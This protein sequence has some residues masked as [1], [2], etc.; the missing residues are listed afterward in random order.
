MPAK[1]P[2]SS[3][4]SSSRNFKSIFALIRKCKAPTKLS[5]AY[6]FKQLIEFIS[7]DKDRVKEM[8][9]GLSE[10]ARSAL[11]EEAYR[12]AYEDRGAVGEAANDLHCLIV[13]LEDRPYAPIRSP[14]E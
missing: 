10:K 8:I 9:N 14:G 11:K 3:S 5:D 12:I 7:T 6:N 2:T 4:N 13:Q 1:Q